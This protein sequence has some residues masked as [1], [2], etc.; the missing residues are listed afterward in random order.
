M[1]FYINTPIQRWH[2]ILSEVGIGS[3]LITDMMAQYIAKN[4]TKEELAQQ[5]FSEE[6]VTRREALFQ[7]IKDMEGLMQQYEE[8]VYMVSDFPVAGVFQP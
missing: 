5:F 6:N 3:T 7:G 2:T 1:L 4:I 8:G